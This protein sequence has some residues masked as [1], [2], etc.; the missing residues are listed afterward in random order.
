MEKEILDYT[1][2]RVNED[3]GD[4]VAA[5]LLVFQGVPQLQTEEGGGGGCN[6]KRQIQ[7]AHSSL[8]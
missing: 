7:V 8:G 4:K 1:H 2:V 5:V 6:A 3:T